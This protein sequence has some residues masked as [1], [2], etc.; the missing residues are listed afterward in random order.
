[1]EKDIETRKDIEELVDEF[2]ARVKQDEM[3]GFI[4]TTALHID[5][6]KHLPVMYDFWENVLFYSGG[7]R[8]N[9]L[10]THKYLH[11]Q[12]PLTKEYFE[13]WVALFHHVVDDMF[14]GPNASLIKNRA[15][16][17]ANVMQLKIIDAGGF[18]TKEL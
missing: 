18:F 7:Y 5:W 9:P 17:I 16:S 15:S 1:M 13:C 12:I 14:S 11:Q 8:G 4:F 3:I 10:Q 6:E 2:Y